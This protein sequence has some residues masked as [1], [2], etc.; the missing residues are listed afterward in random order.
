M[1]ANSAI[2]FDT[3]LP[4][5]AGARRTGKLV[6]F[7]GAGMSM[8]YCRGWV[9]FIWHLCG[10]VGRA[11]LARLLHDAIE[12]RTR[13]EKVNPETLYRVADRV[14]G[15]L[16]LLPSA[17]RRAALARA[18]RSTEAGLPPQ[19][20]A[21]TGPNWPLIVT[22]NY[23]DLIVAALER[24]GAASDTGRRSPVVLGRRRADCI[25]VVH[26]LDGLHPPIVWHVQ[27][28]VPGVARTAPDEISPDQEAM[29]EQI[30]LGH[31]EY[32]QAINGEPD[33]RRAFAEVFRRRSL[34]FLGSGLAESYIVNLLSE[35]LFTFGPSPH[36]HYALM[37]E[38]EAEQADPEFLAMRL[39]ITAVVYGKRHADLPARL[40]RLVREPARPE[41]PVA[42]RA[43]ETS[44]ANSPPVGRYHR[45]L[46]GLTFGLDHVDA[47]EPVELRLM[48]GTLPTEMPSAGECV[49]LSVG[50]DPD[51]R[52]SFTRIAFGKQARD[53]VA[54][55]P[56]LDDTA[57]GRAIAVDR[58][59][60]QAS[61]PHRLFRLDGWRS[62][63]LASATVASSTD[64]ADTRDLRTI[65]DATRLVLEH[66]SARYSR[67]RMGLLGAGALRAFDAGY[68]LLAQLSGVRG[69]L[70]L[71]GMRGKLGCIEVHVA[72]PEAW[73]ALAQGDIPAAE[74]LTSGLARVLV[75]VVGKSGRSEE[76]AL[77]VRQGERVTVRDVLDRYGY[78]GDGLDVRAHPFTERGKDSADSGL[79]DTA[80]FPG[81]VIEVSTRVGRERRHETE[82][83]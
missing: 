22:T 43:K 80:V 38:Q 72:D 51:D 23:D 16:R 27:G 21:L 8:G 26:S 19:L 69:F 42:R 82:V 74:L 45:G 44:A 47:G 76:F 55:C 79:L 32:Q 41:Q 7:I 75:R 73:R 39:G 31:Q 61:C 52:G 63:Y 68:C 34:L 12:Q 24:K 67:V 65:T 3:A 5:L 58:P 64:L 28:H 40:E 30:V 78:S 49:V 17:E 83:T 60:L 70:E 46:R 54:E 1:N 62:V 57:E 14:A 11:D 6:P 25:D 4:W 13:D 15:L 20:L 29:L 37:T 35:A 48:H 9:D 36:P 50:L 56:R 77:S 33:F 71:P 18:L 2:D 66:L 81:M 53:F 59:A 10:N